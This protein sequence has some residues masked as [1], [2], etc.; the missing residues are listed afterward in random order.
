MNL[1]TLPHIV[2]V[3]GSITS[4][5]GLRGQELVRCVC[6][7]NPTLAVC[8]ALD[9]CTANPTLPECAALDGGDSQSGGGGQAASVKTC[10]PLVL[11]TH[12]YIMVKSLSLICCACVC[13]CAFPRLNRIVCWS[14]W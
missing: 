6:A 7:A 12:T 1:V 5:S 9:A 10:I 14:G 8:A 3:L 13:V 2:L 11:P 4:C